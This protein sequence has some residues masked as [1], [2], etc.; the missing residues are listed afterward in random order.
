M[1][2][3]FTAFYCLNFEV[4]CT[5]I[6]RTEYQSTFLACLSASYNRVTEF[7]QMDKD[8]IYLKENPVTA[9]PT[10]AGYQ[11]LNRQTLQCRN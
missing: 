7:I 1:V 6:L 8:V 10:L 3:V 2:F 9:T 11:P 5:A 4:N